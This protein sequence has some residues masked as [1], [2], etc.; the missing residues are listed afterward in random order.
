MWGPQRCARRLPGSE[1]GLNENKIAALTEMIC[2]TSDE[3]AA[4]LLVLMATL[5]KLYAPEGTRESSKAP[6]LYSVS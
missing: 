5:E 6:C 2:R 1:H 3:S 4:A